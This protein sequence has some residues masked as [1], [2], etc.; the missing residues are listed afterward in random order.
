MKPVKRKKRPA[1]LFLAEMDGAQF[2]KFH[3]YRR[4]FVETEERRREGKRLQKQGG[5]ADSPKGKAL[6]LLRKLPETDPRLLDGFPF[7][8]ARA[9]ALDEAV[10]SIMAHMEERGKEVAKVEARRRE[11][12]LDG[13]DR[14]SFPEPEYW[15]GRESFRAV[16][17][18][19]FSEYL[20]DEPFSDPSLGGACWR[21]TDFSPALIPYALYARTHRCLK[22]LRAL[23]EQ[24]DNDSLQKLVQIVVPLVKL[25]NE[26]AKENPDALGD[27]PQQLP[28][29]PVLKSDHRDFDEDH[30]A[31]LK[32]LQ[33]GKDFPLVIA[34]GAR[35]TAQ[36]AIGRWAIHL[37]HEID[38]MQE[39]HAVDEDS[40]MW[41]QKLPDLKPFS[42]ATWLTWWEVAQGLLQHEYVDVVEIPE[43][44]ETVKSRADRKSP[45]RIRKR[46][47]QGLKNKFK[48]MAG[49]NKL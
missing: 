40:E 49:E 10:A 36:D 24:G 29:W 8:S 34:E 3:R 31:L 11:Q 26:K 33:V 39:G 14:A 48:S 45:G 17:R 30:G 20:S 18:K 5:P 27:V 22:P 25:I 9:L 7:E 4:W 13:F 23:A 38:I 16:L 15:H 37:C 32:A 44:N 21:P 1:R 28:F 47:L 2:E 35:W 19:A 46:I 43:L 12:F 41:E 42:A 6:E